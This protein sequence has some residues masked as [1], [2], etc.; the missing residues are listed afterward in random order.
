MTAE[1]V[2]ASA[3]EVE[4]FLEALDAAELDDEP[5]TDDDR[6][7]VQAGSD[8]YAR[9]ESRPWTDVRRLLAVEDDIAKRT[10]S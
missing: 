8:A 4:P 6:A 10:A 3:V 7:A 5:F 1:P 2:V 9:G